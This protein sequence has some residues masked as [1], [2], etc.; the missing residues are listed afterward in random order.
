M[1]WVRTGERRGR[2][3]RGLREPALWGTGTRRRPCRWRSGT[4]CSWRRCPWSSSRPRALEACCVPGHPLQLLAP[5][6]QKKNFAMV[7]QRKRK[8]WNARAFKEIYR[9]KKKEKMRRLVNTRYKCNSRKRNHPRHST[10]Q[11]HMTQASGRWACVCVRAGTYAQFS[12]GVRGEGHEGRRPRVYWRVRVRG[13]RRREG[14]RR[15][16]GVLRLAKRDLKKTLSPV[17]VLC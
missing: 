11:T 8:R 9:T 7:P 16:G 14:A 13:A 2:A 5:T 3:R 1:A 17:L 15:Q 6:Q 4:S 12:R 10:G